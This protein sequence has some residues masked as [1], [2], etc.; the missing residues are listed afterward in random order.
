M[1]FR[2]ADG[3][4]LVIGGLIQ[5]TVQNVEDQTPIF[6]SIP[7][8]G[9]LFQSKARQPVTTAIIFLIKVVSWIRPADSI[10]IADP[11]SI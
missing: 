4:N 2:S 7:I 10:G 3:T 11:D 6:G 9:R 8:V 5:E 1:L